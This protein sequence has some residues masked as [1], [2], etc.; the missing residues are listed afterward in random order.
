MANCL[1]CGSPLIAGARF[2]SSCG[3]KIEN[4]VMLKPCA[5][6]MSGIAPD[7]NFCPWC[8]EKNEDVQKKERTVVISNTTPN[9]INVEGGAFFMGTGELTHRVELSSF[10]ISIAPITQAQYKYV[11]GKSPSK[12]SGEDLPVESVDWC[13]AIRYC[14]ELSKRMNLMPCYSIGDTTDFS[15]T[16]NSSPI[17][18]RLA[19]NFLAN[20]FRLPTEAEWEYAARGGKKGTAFIYSGSDTIDEV[21]WYGENSFVTT[22]SVC[23]KK[24]NSLGIYDMC[25]NVAE[26][27]YDEYAEYVKK[28]QV[29]PHGPNAMTGLHVKRGGSWLDDPEQ[30][31]VFFRS[32]SPQNGKSSNLGFRICASLIQPTQ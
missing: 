6:C 18:K 30:C 7:A 22:H 17:W 1:K 13:D 19:C 20:G 8:G 2:C 10:K 32:G 12:F 26:W 3:T 14:N 11:M 24:A 16:A 25:G 27:I 31:C 4:P 28:P 21:A 5:K 9:M 15:T 29:N 23:E